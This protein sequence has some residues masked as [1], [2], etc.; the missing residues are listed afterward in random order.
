MTFVKAETGEFSVGFGFPQLS[1]QRADCVL[2]MSKAGKQG[3]PHKACVQKG[4]T[5]ICR[6]SPRL[7]MH[8]SYRLI[9]A[10]HSTIDG[11]LVASMKSFGLIRCHPKRMIHLATMDNVRAI[12]DTD[13]PRRACLVDLQVTH[14]KPHAATPF[15]SF[16]RAQ[17]TQRPQINSAP[18]WRKKFLCLVQ[19]P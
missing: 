16:S 9:A 12:W 17:H 8:I 7:S 11:A 15:S 2:L 18:L 6:C 19:S 1:D 3:T 13:A 14:A 5:Q 4:L 10:P